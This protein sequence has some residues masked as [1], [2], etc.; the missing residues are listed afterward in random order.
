MIL[1]PCR[2]QNSAVG[3]AT[4]YGLDGRGVGVRDPVG[5]GFSSRHVV[6]TGSGAH[7]DSNTMDTGTSFPGGK[8]DGA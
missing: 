4:G 1:P 5:A 7:P 6:Q 2:S 3:T 8:A